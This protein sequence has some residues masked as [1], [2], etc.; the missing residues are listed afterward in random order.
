MYITCGDSP[1]RW[2]VQRTLLDTAF[3]QRVHHRRDFGFEQ[4]EVAHGHH[5][6]AAD[7]L[8]RRQRSERQWRLDRYTVQRHR[9]IDAREAHF[10][11]IAWQH[12]SGA[13]D[14]LLYVVPVPRRCVR[15]FRRCCNE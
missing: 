1:I 12:R 5:V 11:H 15:G 9:Q 7:L 14:R 8:V 3:L 6:A 10:A 2:F 13:A 4:D